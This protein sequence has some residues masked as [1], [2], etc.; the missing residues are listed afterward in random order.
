[1]SKV[2]HIVNPTFRLD[3]DGRLFKERSDNP[4]IQDTL[5]FNDLYTKLSITKGDLPLFPYIG[6][7]QFLFLFGFN[8]EEEI[9]MNVTSFENAI[10]EQMGRDC[11][12]DYKLDRD[13]KSVELNIGLE[14]LK[15]PIS[16]K[17]FQ[18]QNSIKVIHYEFDK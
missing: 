7:K 1:M 11:V 12:I 8:D 2:K 10:E 15:Y 14:G 16:F 5:I 9:S 4:D 13:D 3:V 17:Y 6:L 18:L